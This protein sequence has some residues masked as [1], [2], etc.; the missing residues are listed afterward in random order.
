MPNL[1][2]GKKIPQ[3][4]LDRAEV[5][6]FY[7]NTLTNIAKRLGYST[8]TLVR[9]SQKH[10]WNNERLP[11]FTF[12]D[13]LEDCENLLFLHL[14]EAIK[15]ARQGDDTDLVRQSMAL[16]NYVALIK[17]LSALA[18]LISSKFVIENIP[19]VI[20][21]LPKTLTD[22]QRHAVIAA[23]EDYAE[24]ARRNMARIQE[25]M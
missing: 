15:H 20:D 19:K 22:E 10:E 5:L 1:S 24:K 17:D 7:G 13:L 11:L 6:H 8:K 25:E 4:V 21:D 9:Y 12:D 16:K 3:R 2:Q 23:L 14:Q 18:P